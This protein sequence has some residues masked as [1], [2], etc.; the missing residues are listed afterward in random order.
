MEG[1]AIAAFIIQHLL[2]YLWMTSHGR[3][4]PKAGKQA[5]RIDTILLGGVVGS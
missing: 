4:W 3:P 2:Q 5:A 1:A